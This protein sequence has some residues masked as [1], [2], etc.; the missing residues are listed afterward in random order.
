MAPERSRKGFNVQDHVY[1]IVEIVG[2]SQTSIEDAIQQAVTRAART[3]DNL[4][5]FQVVETRGHIQDGKVHH[6]QVTLKI[7]FRL[8]EPTQD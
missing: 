8:E 7:G 5:W 4:R 2:S 6:Y 3:L 1:K